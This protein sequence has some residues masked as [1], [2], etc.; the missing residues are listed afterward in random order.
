MLIKPCILVNKMEEQFSIH[1]KIKIKMNEFINITLI[2]IISLSFLKS[3][4]SEALNYFMQGQFL[5]NQGNYALAILEFQDALL[6]DPNRYYTYFN[7]RCI[8]ISKEK[9]SIEHLMIALELDQ[10]I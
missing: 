4:E 10:K 9:R 3:E 2:T 5:L 1:S 6:L 8:S 7:S